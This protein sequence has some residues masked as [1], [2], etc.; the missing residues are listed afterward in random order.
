MNL[1]DELDRIAAKLIEGLTADDL[2]STEDLAA[3]GIDNTTPAEYLASNLLDDC[4]EWP[5]DE[6]SDAEL[7]II[8]SNAD[9]IFELIVA[10]LNSL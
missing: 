1:N 9:A 3:D 7:S 4:D 6:I 5:E 8:E 2:E 10:K